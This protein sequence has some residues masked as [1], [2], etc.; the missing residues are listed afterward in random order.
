MKS[1][2]ILWAIIGFFIG[3]IFSLREGCEWSTAFWRGCIAALTAAVIARW[4]GQVWLDGLRESIK[5][6]QYKRTI[7]VTKPKPS[8]KT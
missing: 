1:F 6:R 5:Q 4:W 8:V 2:M 7:S 3:I